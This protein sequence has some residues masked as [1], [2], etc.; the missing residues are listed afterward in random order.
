M[1][2]LTTVFINNDTS[3]PIA[4]QC[5]IRAQKENGSWYWEIEKIISVELQLGNGACGID[6][7]DKILSRSLAIDLMLSQVNGQQDQIIDALEE[8]RNSD[9]AG[10]REQY[11]EESLF[12][13][14]CNITRVHAKAFYGI[15]LNGGV[16]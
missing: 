13:M 14:A 12:E 10:E 11:K 15:D 9:K 5:S 7:S 8:E 4:V 2:K 16:K 3:N 6:I 1:K